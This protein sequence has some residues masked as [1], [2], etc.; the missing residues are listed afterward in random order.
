MNSDLNKNDI[1]EFLNK[2]FAFIKITRPINVGITFIVVVV[3]ILISQEHPTE[4]NLIIFASLSA[5]L[6]TAGG[7]I[8]NDIYDIEA[9]K[10]SHPD[11]VIV[12]NL[13][14]K[15]QAFIEYNITILL[16]IITGS[17]FTLIPFIIIIFTSIVLV[18]YSAY[19]KK[20]PLLGNL[21]ISGLVGLAFIYGGFVANN[22][23]SAIVPAIFAFLI[24]MIREIVKD[25]QDIDGDKKQNIITYPIKF[26]ISSAKKIINLISVLLIAF[27][28]YPFLTNL[29]KIEYFV[30][31]ILFVDPILVLSIKNLSDK[32]NKNI[33]KVT[34]LLKLNM[35][36]G[37][38]GIYLGF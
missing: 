23:V 10:I 17:K 13:L 25:I 30:V 37:L 27:T 22:P 19:L 1:M 24:N 12:N 8:I 28:F 4:L 20:I 38:I 11:R 2:V 32:Q 36:L 33:N 29:Y 9:D 16:S 31:M 35:I 5:A 34:L 26:G 6:V 15:K 21:V 7:N 3:S 18:T 14:T